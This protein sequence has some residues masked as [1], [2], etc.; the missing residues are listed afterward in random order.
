MRSDMVVPKSSGV[1]NTSVLLPCYS[2]YMACT[3]GPSMAILAPSITS[4]LQT[5]G[6]K[7]KSSL[8]AFEDNSQKLQI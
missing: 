2:Q 4:A 6:I 1:Q 5:A 7:E 8:F 3:K